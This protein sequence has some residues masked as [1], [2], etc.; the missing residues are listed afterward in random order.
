MDVPTEAIILSNGHHVFCEHC[1]QCWLASNGVCPLCRQFVEAEDILLLR[2]LKL[3]MFDL[4][5]ICCKNMAVRKHL[6]QVT[7]MIMKRVAGFQWGR[8]RGGATIR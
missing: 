4:L 1:V 6:N 7:L 2:Q 8:E 5:I 3:A